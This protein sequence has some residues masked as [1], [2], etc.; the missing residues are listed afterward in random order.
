MDVHFETVKP[1]IDKGKDVYVEWPL[2][3]DLKHAEKLRTLAKKKG[4]RTIVGLQGRM[5]PVILKI[6]SLVEQGKIGKVLSSSVV[7]FGGTNDR[8]IVPASLNTSLIKV[9]EVTS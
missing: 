9:W 2:A 5:S 1:S 6:K 7:V 8:H 3:Q 4:S